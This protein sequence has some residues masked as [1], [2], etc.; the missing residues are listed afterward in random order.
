M[1]VR[2]EQNRQVISIEPAVPDT[3]YVPYYEP[4]VVYGDWPY[5]DYP[6][7]PYY[8]GYPGYIAAGVIATGLVFGAA[9]RSDDGRP[10]DTGAAAVTGAAAASTGP[11]EASTSIAAPMS[12]TGGTIRRIDKARGTTMRTCNSGSA[13]PIEGPGSGPGSRPAPA[14]ARPH[15]GWGPAPTGLT[16]PTAPA[17]NRQ[18]GAGRTAGNRQAVGNRAAAARNVRAGR[19]AGRPAHRAASRAGQFR[20]SAGRRYGGGARFAGG[21]HRAAAF[22][23][24]GGF[25]GRWWRIP[26]RRRPWRWRAPLGYHAQARCRTAGPARQRS[27]LLPL[28][29][30]WQREGLCRGDCAGG[31]SHTTRCGHCRSR[32][33]SSGA[34][35]TARTAVPILRRLGRIRRPAAEACRSSAEGNLTAGP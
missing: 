12:S 16:S 9:M 24:G 1:S 7:Y 2:Q 3:L 11:A 15:S 19:A 13:T 32:R 34:L 21:G 6:A 10:A 33:L 28:R 5:A 25:R 30:Q 27:R 22:R 14:P 4:Q 26:R 20:P 18:A 31:Q 8:W 17:A 35:R 29:V 23:G